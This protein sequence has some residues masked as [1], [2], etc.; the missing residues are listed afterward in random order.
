MLIF[1]L[2]NKHYKDRNKKTADEL[3]EYNARQAAGMRRMRAA[4]KAK[5]QQQKQRAAA[6]K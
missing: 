3:A 5:E 4:K 6:G 1:S 2:Q